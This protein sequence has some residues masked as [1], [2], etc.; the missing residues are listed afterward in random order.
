MFVH[1]FRW[2]HHRQTKFFVVLRHA[3]VVQI[4][5]HAITGDGGVEFCRTWQIASALRIQAA[6]A[7]KR[8]G[9]L[10]Y[11]VGAKVE[12]DAGVVIANS[13][14][15]LAAIVGT[16][17]GHDEFVGHVLVVRSL[18]AMHGIHILAAFAVP[19]DHG[20]VSLGDALPAP[21]AVH[22]IVAA[23]DAWQS[24]RCC[25]RAFSAAVV[26]GSRRHWWAECRAHP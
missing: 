11:A 16:D 4:L 25:T 13:R 19:K 7:G 9:D 6:V 5:G 3:D 26:Q 21:V 12:A 17:K 22:G 23:V 18:N 2:N 1:R 10:P 8:A 15:R 14:Q 24:C 20:V